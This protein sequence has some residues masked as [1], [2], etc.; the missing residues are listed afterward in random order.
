ME[1]IVVLILLGIVFLFIFPILAL[2]KLNRIKAQ[3]DDMEYRMNLLH[4]DKKAPDNKPEIPQEVPPSPAEK[5]VAARAETIQVAE[6]TVTAEPE[7]KP[8]IPEIKVEIAWESSSEN[9]QGKFD[10]LLD[11]QTDKL[12]AKLSEFE[13]RSAAVLHLVWS[14]ICVGEEFRS[15]KVSREYAIATTWLIRLGVIILLCGIGFFLKYSIDRNW[16][17]P[18]VRVSLMVIAG[19]AMAVIGSW[20]SRGKYRP[21]AIALSGAGF[22]TL[23]LSIMAAYKLYALIPAIPAFLFMIVVTLSAMASALGTNALLTALLGCAGGYLTPIF[24]NTNSGNTVALFIYMTV[25]SC[26]TLMVAHYRNW[27]LLNAASFL[28][29]AVIG[30][31]AIANHASNNGML[32][33]TGLL[34][35]NFA[36]FSIQ[37]YLSSLK[38]D[39][40]LPEV[41]LFCGNIIFFLACALP[42]AYKYFK[43]WELPALLTLFAALLAAGEL[44]F[45]MKK[46][47]FPAKILAIFLQIQLCFFLALTIPLLFGTEWVIAAW[48]IL[49]FLL[50]DAACKTKSKTLLVFAVLIYIAAAWFECV[51]PTAFHEA[52]ESFYQ[53]LVNHLLTAG[54][55]IISMTCSAIRLLRNLPQEIQEENQQTH[56]VIGGLAQIFIA[57]AGFLFFYCS[58]FEL[59]LAMHYHF[60]PFKSGILV[61]YWSILLL[62]AT[63]VLNK[64]RLHK[65]LFVP[66]VLTILAGGWMLISG[67][68]YHIASQYWKSFCFTLFTSGIYIASM[69]LTARE[70]FRTSQA[71]NMPIKLRQTLQNLSKIYY[72]L[73][74]VLFFIYSSHELYEFLACYLKDF[75]NGGVSVYWSA[76]AFALL[77]WGLRKQYKILRMCGIALFVVVALKI[78]FID[79]AKLEQIWR[80]VAFAAIGVVMLIGAVV[81]IRCKDMFIKEEG[82]E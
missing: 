33:L 38:R 56:N 79:L 81:Y 74:G 60:M 73:A 26:G 55:Y 43:E 9:K 23:Y 7:N 46:G 12:N 11:R 10:E 62:I 51:H 18:A 20:K 42:G 39:M 82:Q 14:W 71:E 45:M 66:I 6:K 25:L 77:V 34:T 63:W 76:L 3:L 64:Y 70:F 78:F 53:Q 24:I 35:L 27:L 22:V 61:T 58:S 41:L 30:G 17:P 50:V 44:F 36:V 29:Y 13:E 32:A 72:S 68:P 37:N 47:L 67:E 1:V 2:V 59:H 75:R 80:I 28:F 65:L 16:T 69:A 4:A 48:S 15:Q 5:P 21:L 8:L 54:V 52:Y 31:A 40:T 49:A 19:A 57:I